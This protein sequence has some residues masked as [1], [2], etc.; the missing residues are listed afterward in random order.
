M[1][2]AKR[3]YQRAVTWSKS[4]SMKADLHVYTEMHVRACHMLVSLWF[5]RPHL[6]S[7]SQDYFSSD[8]EKYFDCQA[9]VTEMSAGLRIAGVD[10]P[11]LLP[12]GYLVGDNT[13]IAISLKGTS[14]IG[15]TTFSHIFLRDYLL[16]I[17]HHYVFCVLYI[18]FYHCCF[19]C[20][21][22]TW[23]YYNSLYYTVFRKN[24]HSHFLSY[25]HE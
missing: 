14:T 23:L 5:V 16:C 1:V 10:M 13:N 6:S 19:Y 25:L 20:P 4:K 8:D 9:A 11:E 24:T 2:W 18:L 12:C 22:H 3:N 21:L 15:F 7:F 17:I